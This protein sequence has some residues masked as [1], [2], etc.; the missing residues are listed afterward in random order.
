MI[1][2][3]DIQN[4][5]EKTLRSLDGITRAEANPFL[6]TRIKARMQKQSR[7]ENVISFISRPV[8]VFAVFI[9]VLTVNGLF[10]INPSEENS[11]NENESIATLDF[12]DEYNLGST[13]EYNYENLQNE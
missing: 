8:V 11:T 2:N 5:V 7:W 12:D 9:M 3:K 10:L 4:E 6:Y 13:T 1:D